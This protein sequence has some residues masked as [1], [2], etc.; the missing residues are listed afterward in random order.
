MLSCRYSF[1][2][3]RNEKKK[4]TIAVLVTAMVMW[5]SPLS[6]G[7]AAVILFWV[8]YLGMGWADQ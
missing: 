4:I 3:E 2:G 5:W 1:K 7:E 6:S 8:A